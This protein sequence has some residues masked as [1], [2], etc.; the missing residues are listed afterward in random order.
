MVLLENL[1]LEYIISER[2]KLFLSK[3]VVTY[4]PL[5]TCNKNIFHI[6]TRCEEIIAVTGLT[7]HRSA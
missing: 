6:I 1:P 2:K 4:R 5:N 7:Y 3:L